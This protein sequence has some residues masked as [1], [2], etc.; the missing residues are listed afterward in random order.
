M[1]DPRDVRDSRSTT[2]PVAAEKRG[3]SVSGKQ[4]IPSFQEL[5]EEGD[6]VL[7]TVFDLGGSEIK[8]SRKNEHSLITVSGG[9]SPIVIREIEKIA[10]KCKGSIGLEFHNVATGPKAWPAALKTPLLSLLKNLKSR[11]ELRGETF[12]LSAPPPK[13][14]DMLKLAGVYERYIILDKTGALTSGPQ[15]TRAKP[16]S[17]VRRLGRSA[18]SPEH[19]EKAR[20]R[21]VHFNHSLKRTA[22]LEKG[23]DS[24]EKCVQ[25]FLPQKPPAAEGYDF[26]FSYRSSEKVGGDFFDFIWLDKTTLGISI[27]DVSGHGIDAALI[28]GISKKL[29]NIRAQDPRF[30]TPGGVLK[31]VNKDVTTDLNRQTFVTALYGVLDL[32]SGEFRF[33]RAGHEPPILFQPGKSQATVMSKGIALGLG[34]ERYFNSQIEDVSVKLEPGWCILLC[35]DG[36][37]ECRNEKEAIYGR[38][39]LVFE[40]NQA[41]PRKPAEQMLNQLLGSIQK[42]A[43]DRAQEDDM[44]AILIQRLSA[45]GRIGVT[46]MKGKGSPGGK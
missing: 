26:A 44:T 18:K 2:R 1:G 14:E 20:K 17:S 11:C 43:G 33:A 23:L 8:W 9:C 6:D 37:A 40:L 19:A 30:K 5:T 32:E 36:L 29:I 31:Q 3:H 25:K 41:D 27:G 35:T 34:I 46:R 21:I 22:S 38:E 16:G 24:A 13:L 45:S 28:M 42:F 10:R 39:R 4:I 7:T 12:F 15:P